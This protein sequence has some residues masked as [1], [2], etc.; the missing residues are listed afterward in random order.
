MDSHSGDHRVV[1]RLNLRCDKQISGRNLH[2]SSICRFGDTMVINDQ[3]RVSEIPIR[4]P[5]K[6]SCHRDNDP[7]SAL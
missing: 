5:S 4:R 2:G 6:H 7:G 3:T 1:S